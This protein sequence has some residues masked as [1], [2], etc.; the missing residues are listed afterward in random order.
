MRRLLL[1]ALLAGC[2]SA[3]PA[4]TP[5]DE[6]LARFSHAGDIAYNLEE[7]NQAAEQ[8]RAALSRARER[9]DAAA[10]AD[11]GF[12][13]ATAELRA[14]KPQDAIRTCH[15]LQAELGRRGI[16]DPAFDLVIA[17]AHFRVGEYAMAERAASVLASGGNRAL[18]DSAWFL[19]GLI[20]DERGDGAVLRQA[21]AALS[22]SSNA[23]DRLELQA[24]IGRDPV[25]ALR[26]ADS[27]RD[28]LDY[29][30]MARALALAAQFSTDA[31]RASDLY[32]RAG[33]SAA[34]QKNIPQARRWLTQARATAPNPVLRADAERALAEL[35]R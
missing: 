20:A 35:P 22:P 4:A 15:S 14:D 31:A 21:A 16:A 19:R 13:L 5:S 27:R 6:T 26:A 18:A 28:A 32:L 34:A 9:D 10:I 24:R 33:Q 3:P 17:T 11:A 12:N 7:A 2:S 30:G 25:L 1:L 8:Y 23:A 29:R